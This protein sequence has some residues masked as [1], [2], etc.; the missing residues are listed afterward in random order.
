MSS[1]RHLFLEGFFCEIR[2]MPYLLKGG[3]RFIAICHCQLLI[4]MRQWQEWYF[5]PLPSYRLII[6]A[7]FLHGRREKGMGVQPTCWKNIRSHALTDCIPSTP[8]V[9]KRDL[10]KMWLSVFLGWGKTQGLHARCPF[11]GKK[12]LSDMAGILFGLFLNVTP[13]WSLRLLTGGLSLNIVA[14]CR[15]WLSSLTS[16]LTFKSCFSNLPCQGDL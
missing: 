12:E 14:R 2:E 6:A 3:C 11:K 7:V 13:R 1:L 16:E 8:W 9:G 10:W 15:G 5:H 4:F